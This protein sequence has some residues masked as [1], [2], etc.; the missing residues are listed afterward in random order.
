M[1]SL[2]VSSL[3]C[4]GLGNYQKRR[5]VFQHLRQKQ[6][7]IYC[8]QDLHF[9]HKM[10]R[11]VRAEWGYECVFAPNNTRSRGVGILFNSNFDFKIKKTVI[12]SAGNFIIL[13]MHTMGKDIVLVNIYGP[14]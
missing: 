9:D 1:S 13:L 6:Y 5:D 2:K 11:Q 14:N 12:D 3:N 7:N 4:Q 8:L 10:V